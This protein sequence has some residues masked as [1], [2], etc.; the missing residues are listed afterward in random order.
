M[1]VSARMSATT[2]TVTLAACIAAS[3]IFAPGCLIVA[4]DDSTLTV[5]ND[6][7]FVIEEINVTEV[8]NRDWGPNLIPEALFPGE[9]VEIDLDCDTYDARLIDEDDVECVIDSIDLCFDDALWRVRNNSC[10]VWEAARKT[11][12]EAAAKQQGQLDSST[13]QAPEAESQL[14]DQL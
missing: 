7:D 5:E 3:A 10:A 13:Q 6:S 11:R 4:D 14:W 2:R 1:L 9:T 8:D 12:Q